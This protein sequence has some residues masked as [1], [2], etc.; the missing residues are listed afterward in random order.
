[1]WRKPE[2]VVEREDVDAVLA[3]LIDIRRELIRIR[4]MLEED[5]DAEGTDS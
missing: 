5:D 4:T 3:A 2:T 1:M